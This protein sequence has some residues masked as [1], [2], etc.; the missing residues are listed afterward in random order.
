DPRAIVEQARSGQI[1]EAWRVI[2]PRGGYPA[3][4]AARAFGITLVALFFAF[5]ILLMLGIAGPS[6][7]AGVANTAPSWLEG[8]LGL[9]YSYGLLAVVAILAA[10]VVLAGI[11]AAGNAPYS[12]IVLTPDG[13]VQSLGPGAIAAIDFAAIDEITRLFVITTTAHQGG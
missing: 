3:R 4:A 2:R 9:L 8:L 6:L 13:L 7:F 1:P 12:F 10:A 11:R 5:V